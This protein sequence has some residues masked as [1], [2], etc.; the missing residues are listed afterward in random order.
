M[1]GSGGVWGLR[2]C[3]P[4]AL[5]KVEIVIE[6]V[7]TPSRLTYKALIGGREVHRSLVRSFRL[8]NLQLGFGKGPVIES[9]FTAS[10]YRGLHIY[11]QVLN[12]ILLDLQATTAAV[13][14]YI[15]AD[16]ENASSIAGMERAGFE[17]VARCKGL[18]LGPF[19]VNR[20]REYRR[21]GK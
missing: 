7:S 16:P 3:E 14:V 11:P 9:C 19:I 12:H 2:S 18:C 4:K 6:K 20:S 15:W 8:R 10:E 5:A 17:F 21:D 1:G 13:E